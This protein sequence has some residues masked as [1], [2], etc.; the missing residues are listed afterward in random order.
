MTDELQVWQPSQFDGSDLLPTAAQ[1]QEAGIV[2]SDVPVV[3]DAI[4]AE[5]IRLPTLQVLQGTSK[6]VQDAVEGAQPGKLFFSGSNEVIQPPARV[7]VVHRFRGNAMF[8]RNDCPPTDTCELFNNDY[9]PGIYTGVR[10]Y[11]T[12]GVLGARYLLGRAGSDDVAG[13]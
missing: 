5:D 1:P 11:I 6:P 2:P 3:D 9:N 10:F 12:E 7:L 4:D 8:V 13:K